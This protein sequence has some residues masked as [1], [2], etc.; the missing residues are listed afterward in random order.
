MH[1]NRGAKTFLRYP[2]EKNRQ[3]AGIP[4]TKPIGPAKVT[5]VQLSRSP[6]VN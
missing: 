1:Y 3:G 4:Q 2:I 5:S 6:V